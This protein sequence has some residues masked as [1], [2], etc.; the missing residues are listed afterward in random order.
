MVHVTSAVLVAALV[1]AP[2]LAAPVATDEFQSYGRDLEEFDARSTTG[3]RVAKKVAENVVESVG[4][5]Q[6]KDTIKK[7]TNPP[8]QV[9][10]G[11]KDAAKK[12][13]GPHSQAA[14]DHVVKTHG[15]KKR[16]FDFEDFEARSTTGGRVAKK[17]AENVVESA[18]Q[19]TFKDTVKKY[20]N[21]PVQVPQ[22]LK[23]AAKKATSGHSQAAV[24]H[25]VKSHGKKKRSFDFEDFETRSTTGGRIAKKVAENVAES[26][27]QSQFKDTLKK[28]TKPPVQVPQGLV[29]AA[30]KAT[31]PHSQAAV[32]WVVKTHGKKKRSFD[33]DDF[34]ARSTTGGRIAK[35]VAENVVESAGQ[36][37]FKDAVKKYTNPPV[38]VPQGL[39]D[40]AKKATSGHSQ[41]AVDHVVKSHGKKK[42]SFDFEDLEARSTT[43]GRVAKKVAENVVESVGQG[44]FKDTVKKYTNPPVQ[45]PQG[46]KDAAKKATSGHSQAAVDH[47]VK[48]HGKKKRSFDF[49]DVEARSTTGGRV[50]KKVAE[51]VVESVGQ[52][53]FKDTLK[54]YTNPPVQVPQGLKDAAK[55]ATSGH[56]QAAVD[57]VVKTHGKK[58][59]DL[60]D[61]DLYERDFEDFEDVF[62]RDLFDDLEERDYFDE[63]EEREFYDLNELD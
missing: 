47:V 38:Q 6:F 24:D 3:G 40:A 48:S 39:K 21:P 5:G 19:S 8:V 31:G 46:L 33:F 32:D 25:V 50:A 51:N 13:T 43:G 14:V 53:Q 18:G 16:S 36:G 10:Q 1:A 37:T 28:Y 57:H 35:K 62:E 49:E 23:D 45:V 63:L 41:A 44:Q 2:V 22:G 26:V 27:G 54:K 4:Q 52:G 29:D 7:Y 34:V 56:S 60:E 42:R 59:R 61:F 58:K 12:A 11:L 55:K 17:V 20:T 15:K 9:P 30:K